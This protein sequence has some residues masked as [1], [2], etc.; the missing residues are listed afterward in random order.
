MDTPNDWIFGKSSCFCRFSLWVVCFSTS[1]IWFWRKDTFFVFIE[2]FTCVIVLGVKYGFGYLDGGHVGN[3]FVWLLWGL[4]FFVL[5][6]NSLVVV[7]NLSL[8]G[9]CVKM[10]LFLSILVEK[11]GCLCSMYFGVLLMFWFWFLVYIQCLRLFPFVITSNKWLL[12]IWI[13]LCYDL[14]VILS[15]VENMWITQLENSALLASGV[16]NSSVTNHFLSMLV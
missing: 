14:L 15:E 9:L 10:S 6:V 4:L 2:M 1:F 12:M 8:F 7:L 5:A 16:W 3:L 13:A 11:S